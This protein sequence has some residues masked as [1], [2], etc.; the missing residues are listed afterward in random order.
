MRVRKNALLIFSKP[1]VPGLV[2][3]RLSTLKDGAFTPEIAAT[4]FHC[5][6][7]DLVEIC[8]DALAELEAREGADPEV[9][10]EY[11]LF[12]S[13][14]P[15]RNLEVMKDIFESSGAWPRDIEFIVDAGSNFDEHYNHSFSQVWERGYDAIL[16]MGADMPALPRR[17]VVDGFEK[18]H[19]LEREFGAGCV[20]SPDQAMAV[21]II[22]WTRDTNMDHTGVYYNEQGVT[23]M[24][25]YIAK[26][27][28]RGVPMLQLEAVPDVDTMLDLVHNATLLEQ[29][30]YCSRFEDLSA[31]G[32]TLDA[33]RQ[34]GWGQ[35]RVMP[36]DL[37]DPRDEIDA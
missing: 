13:T 20:A 35:Y 27:A 16:S 15:E 37:R 2:K 32:R 23:V 26:A 30:E 11:D 22:G 31:P 21:S 3:T 28:E 1:P 19:W 5:M 14:T 24:P 7:F 8:C 10:D 33:L 29:A 34:L 4:L 12:I 36:N 17:I 25:A 6:L 18:L 9:K